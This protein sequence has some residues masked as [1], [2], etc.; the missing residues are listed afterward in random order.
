MENKTSHLFFWLIQVP[1]CQTKE[2]DLSTLT[3]SL[4][5]TR[6]HCLSHGLTVASSFL[7]LLHISSRFSL[8]IRI[9][10]ENN[11]RQ[12]NLL[13]KNVVRWSSTYNKKIK[14]FVILDSET[15]HEE[16]SWKWLS[17]NVGIYQK[18]YG[19]HPSSINL[20][21]V[22]SLVDSFCNHLDIF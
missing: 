9:F 13:S 14:N 21:K 7:K 5:V 19:K 11:Q 18:F 17:L 12:H 2:S 10:E 1:F 22:V 4:C 6:L 15:Y 8:K 20:I 3:V 16:L